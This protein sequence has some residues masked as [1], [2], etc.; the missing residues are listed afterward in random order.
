MLDDAVGPIRG[1]AERGAEVAFDAEQALDRRIV[2]AEHL[3]DVGLGHAKLFGFEQRV[4]GPAG[5]VEPAIV[6][7]SNHRAERE[8]RR[9]RNET[10]HGVGRGIRLTDAAPKFPAPWASPRL[11][12]P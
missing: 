10:G 5:N 11:A 9:T 6:T 8:A 7:L 1:Q 3:V 2:R 12:D 4:V